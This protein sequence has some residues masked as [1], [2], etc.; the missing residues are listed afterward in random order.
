MKAALAVGL[1]V[2]IALVLGLVTL[3]GASTGTVATSATVTQLEQTC[4]VSGPVPGLDAG[5]AAN[6]E[7]IVTASFALSGENGR[8]ARI[9]LMTAAT[10]SGLVNL[11]PM[12]GN[13]DSLGLFQQRASQGWGTPAEEMDPAKATGMFVQRL[14]AV[15]GWPALTPW[16]AA[17]AVQRSAFSDGSNYQ[18][19]WSVTGAYLAAVVED[20]NIAGSCGQGVPTGV[21]GPDD[22]LP[23]G[24][25]I[26]AD[27]PPAHA[28]V[29]AFALAQLGKA[30]VW[31]AA[32]PNAYDCS[33]LTV[34]AWAT[35]GVQL[36]HYTGDQQHEGQA[37][38]PGTLEPG[39]LVLVPGSDSPGPGIAGHVGLYLGYGLVLSAIDPAMGVAVQ[40]YQIFVSGG[41]DALRDPDPTD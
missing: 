37:V 28:Q 22:G 27:T 21:T 4:T 5:Q 17:Q 36:L 19:H 23:A 29:V 32:G 13:L 40:T 15:P 31:A 6:A 33:G 3:A 24:Y 34:A 18:A 9:A 12:A 8:V 26:P 14:L 38:S 20:G 41:I 30:Y 2:V 10:E 11:G 35:V 16:M 39:D 7:A 25:T 1:G